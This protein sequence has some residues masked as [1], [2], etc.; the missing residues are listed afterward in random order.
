MKKLCVFCGSSP[1]HDPRYASLARS[2][3][4][5]M[6][7]QNV[8]LVFGGGH[9]GLMG[10]LADVVLAGKGTVVGVIPQALVDRELAHHELT[11]LHVV[12]TMHERKA[13]M[14]RLSDG[15]VALPGG[16]GT[17]EELF[18]SV[19]W[20]QLS[21][22][23]KPCALLDPDGYFS[24]LLSFLDHATREGF[25]PTRHRSLL[26]QFTNPELLLQIFATGS[27]KTYLQNST[28]NEN[29]V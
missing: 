18:E 22:H 27:S 6:A 23:A 20:A 12:K 13:T 25:I 11:E 8:G 21:L 4:R 10:I 1:G 3:G 2:L 28:E 7:R 24:G 16:F 9:I 17:L 19:T 5:A 14:H 26:K 29:L 15:F